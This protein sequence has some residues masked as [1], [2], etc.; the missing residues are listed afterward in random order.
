M[1]TIKNGIVEHWDKG[2]ELCR[3]SFDKI[4]N[5]DW[6]PYTGGNWGSIPPCPDKPGIAQQHQNESVL[7]K[8]EILKLKERIVEKAI[9][10]YSVATEQTKGLGYAISNKNG[11]V[12]F[13]KDRNAL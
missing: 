3:Y 13:V 12:G 7:T 5:D 2:V 4:L 11:I 6:T 10:N 8:A 1:I 9:L